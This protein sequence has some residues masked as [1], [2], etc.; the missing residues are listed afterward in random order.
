[1]KHS[2][3]FLLLAALPLLG[4]AQQIDDAARRQYNEILEREHKGGRISQQERALLMS[5]YPKLNPPRDSM[6]MTALTDLGKDSYKGEQGGLYPGGENSPPPEHLKAGMEIAKRVV[7]LNAEG[8]PAADGRIALLSIGMSNTTMEYQTFMK[9][10]A[11]DKELNPRLVLVDG[12]QGGQSAVETSDPHANYWKVVDQRV[13]AAGVTANQVQAV[14]MFQVIVAPFRPFPADARRLQS[15]MADTLRLA[16]ERFPNLKIAYLSSRIYAGF[17]AVPQNPEPHS[18]E[19]GFAPKWII[20]DQIAGFP[21]FNYDPA[22]GSVRFPWVAWGP[23]M[24]ADGV[25][26]RK[27]GVVWPREDFG[28]DGMHPSMLGREKVAKMLLQF[29]KTDPTFP[30]LVSGA[31]NGRR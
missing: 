6:G 4:I 28:P 3:R 25:K 27:D 30:P 24:W 21:E 5:V 1:M 22:R 23:Y 9:R 10:A 26:G 15:L 19:S 16:H 8:H 20:G 13:A 29:L 18:Y 7:P 14:W 2:F 31:V 12:A 11:E 17:A